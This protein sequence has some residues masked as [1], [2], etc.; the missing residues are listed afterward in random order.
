M[1]VPSFD[2]VRV[3]GLRDVAVAKP[4][5]ESNPVINACARLSSF[6]CPLNTD[7]AIIYSRPDTELESR[8]EE[9]LL[10][11]QTRWHFDPAQTP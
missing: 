2:N 9:D 8:W 1:L 10:K 7:C 4:G 6:S 5:T 3:P 11:E